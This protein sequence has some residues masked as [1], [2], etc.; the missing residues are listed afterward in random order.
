M[1][2]LSEK[3][4][5]AKS[6]P[7]LY[8]SSKSEEGNCDHPPLRSHVH[9]WLPSP[10]PS[11]VHSAQMPSLRWPP[12]VLTQFRASPT[13]WFPRLGRAALLG[14]W[15]LRVLSCKGFWGVAPISA[16]PSQALGGN[17]WA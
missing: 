13:L 17:F 3:T 5:I 12:A 7:G 10:A 16:T 9:F 4:E 11:P 8:V 6:P 2:E 1:D 14:P 15:H